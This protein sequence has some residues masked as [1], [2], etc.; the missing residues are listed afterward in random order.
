VDVDEFE[1]VSVAAWN[2]HDS[3]MRGLSIGLFNRTEELHGIQVG[4]LNY[5]GNNDR[6]RWLPL[7]N[8]HF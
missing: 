6:Y 7:I 8:A 5:A 1:G 2:Q 4:L 3:R